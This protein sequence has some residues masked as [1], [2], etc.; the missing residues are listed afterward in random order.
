MLYWARSFGRVPSCPQRKL[1]VCDEHSALSSANPG[2]I[3]SANCPFAHLQFFH[4]AIYGRRNIIISRITVGRR[5][6]SLGDAKKVESGLC[7]YFPSTPDLFA[8]QSFFCQLFYFFLSWRL[9]VR[10]LAT[11]TSTA[12]GENHSSVNGFC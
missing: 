12:K 6:F 10:E 5:Q 3:S 2:K 11:A 8:R 4:T 9:I 7:S 1:G